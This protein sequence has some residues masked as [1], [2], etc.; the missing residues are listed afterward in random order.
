MKQKPVVSTKAKQEQQPKLKPNGV[1]AAAK[2]Q[3]PVVVVAPPNKP[4][5][6]RNHHQVNRIDPKA[7]DGKTKNSAPSSLRMKLK[8]EIEDLKRQQQRQKERLEA[9]RH[10]RKVLSFGGKRCGRFCV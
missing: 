8:K 6:P 4:S 7:V 5:M 2:S 3:P 10:R 9:E 1:A